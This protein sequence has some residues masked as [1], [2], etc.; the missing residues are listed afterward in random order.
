[1]HHIVHG[2]QGCVIYMDDAVMHSDTS[3]EDLVNISAFR[4]C[5]AA[6]KMNVNFLLLQF[7]HMV[8]FSNPLLVLFEQ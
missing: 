8:I 5:L 6:A 3:E 7:N 2:L 4:E 1:M